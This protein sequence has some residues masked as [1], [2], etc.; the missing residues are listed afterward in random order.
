MQSIFRPGLFADQVIVVSGGGTG[1]GRATARELAALGAH[2]VICSRSPEHLEPTRAE[3]AAAGGAV[4]ALTCNIR[5]PES[6][7]ALFATVARAA[8]ARAWAGEQRGRPVH[9]PGGGDHAEGL[10]RG[11]RDESH[12][13]ISDGAGG[14]DATGCARMA[15]LSSTSC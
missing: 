15:A 7:E 14:V 11:R 5:D 10:A 3:I 9:Q 12:R 6:V 8:G 2:V 13:R 1:I 4:T